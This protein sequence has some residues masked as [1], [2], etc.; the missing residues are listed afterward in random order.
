MVISYTDSKGYVY[1][2]YKGHRFHN[3]CPHI[4]IQ[5]KT[6]ETDEETKIFFIITKFHNGSSMAYTQPL[7]KILL[8]SAMYFEKYGILAVLP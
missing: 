4:F 5:V 2:K 1:V 8:K 6:T 3:V 7:L